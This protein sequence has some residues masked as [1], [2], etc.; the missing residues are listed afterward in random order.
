MKVMKFGGTSVGSIEALRHVKNIVET[1]HESVV[2]VVSAMSGVT[3]QLLELC[4]LATAGDGTWGT[5]LQA[6]EERHLTVATEVVRPELQEQCAATIRN[7]VER[8]LQP[9]LSMLMINKD[10]DT[11]ARDRLR[12]VVVANG[13]ILSSAVVSGMLAD[14]VPHLSLHFITTT[15]DDAGRIVDWPATERLVKQ[16]FDQLDGIHV[17]QGFIASD[18]QSHQVTNLGRGGSDY[19]AAIVA[20]VLQAD[21]LEIWTDVDGFMTAD[22]RTHADATVL[23]RMT[24]AQAQQMCDA[25]ARVIY[26]PT[27]APVAQRNIPVWVKNTF[28]PDAPG[29]LIIG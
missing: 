26:P 13:E 5:V 2:V 28:N 18:S 25:G 7:F 20:A 9:Y 16:E 29:T 8:N 12:D 22:P 1:C 4:D 3:N 17:M 11:E 27:I 10:L 19:S 14:A 21:A 6:M 24:Y 23:P 15:S